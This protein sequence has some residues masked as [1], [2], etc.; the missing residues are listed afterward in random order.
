MIG[1]DLSAGAKLSVIKIILECY[2]VA[3]LILDLI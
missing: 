3:D 2:Y 1:L